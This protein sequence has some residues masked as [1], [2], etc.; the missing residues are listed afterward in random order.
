MKRV[1]IAVLVSLAAV[2]ALFVWA[3]TFVLNAASWGGDVEV[4]R[5]IS[6]GDDPRL[7]LDIYHPASARGVL[8]VVIFFYGGSWQHGDKSIYRFLGA[9]LARAGMVV[10][11]PD[12]R[13]YPPVLYP[14]F[15][16]DSAR[17]VRWTKDNVARF[18]GDASKLFLAGHSAGAYNAVSLATDRRW[19]A[20]VKL[21][22]KA[23][24]SGV[25]GI[26]GPYDFLPLK[27]E[28]LKII[29]GPENARPATQPIN[30]VNGDEPPL[31]LLR[32]ADD[33]VVDPGNSSRLA[34]RIEEKGGEALLKTYNHVGHLSIIGTM[35]PLLSVLAPTKNDLVEFVRQR[36]MRSTSAAPK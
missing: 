1:W 24:L 5:D 21:D 30:Y 31:L 34:K 15:L 26:A 29:F 35:S 28:F 7:K 22:A 9:S 3:P 14:D 10:V 13:L 12:Y 32:P 16:R 11:I 23:D 8:P 2:A 4:E 18:G 6:F 27:D 36:S 25:I 20:E 19:L 33:T 17:S